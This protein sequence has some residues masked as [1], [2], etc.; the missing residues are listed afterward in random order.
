[1]SVA[2][3]YIL[4]NQHHVVLYVGSTTDLKKRAYIAIAYPYAKRVSDTRASDY[5]ASIFL[6]GDSSLAA[7]N[8]EAPPFVMTKPRTSL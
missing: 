4:T 7:R 1:M 6:G 2:Y 5:C 3:T 8:D